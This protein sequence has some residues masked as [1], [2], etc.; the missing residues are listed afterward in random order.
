MNKKNVK[1]FII[2]VILVIGGVIY[3]N[4]HNKIKNLKQVINEL[5]TMNSNLY[6]AK[7]ANTNNSNLQT[8]K[9][10]TY[11]FIFNYPDSVSFVTPTYSNLEEKILQLQIPQS[12]YPKTN[13]GDAAFSVSTTYAKDLA[14]CLA[15]NSPENSD[16]FKTPIKI[17]DATFYKTSSSGVGAGNLYEATNYRTLTGTGTCIELVETIHTANIANYT[18]GSVTQVDKVNVQTRLDHILNTFKLN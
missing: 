17:N 3:I 16:G 7:P 5:E 13:F 1:V 8:Y 4:D 12:D 14:D 6:N 10:T 18:P 2:L 11:N 9:N 15:K